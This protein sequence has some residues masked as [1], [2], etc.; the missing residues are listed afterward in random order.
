MR[1]FALSSIPNQ[2]L[3]TALASWAMTVGADPVRVSD[4]PIENVLV[5]SDAA[6]AGAVSAG[7]ATSQDLDLPAGA[8]ATQLDVSELKDVYVKAD[9]AGQQVN[10]TAAVRKDVL[11]RRTSIVFKPGRAEPVF[12]S[13][14]GTTIPLTRG[15]DM[16][17]TRGTSRT[18]VDENGVL[19]TLDAHAMALPGSGWI[20]E[21]QRTNLLTYS[22]D[23]SSWTNRGTCTVTSG[24]ADPDGGT[25]AALLEDNDAAYNEARH[26]TITLATSTWYAA[27]VYLKAGSASTTSLYM[28]SGTGPHDFLVNVAWSG[29]VPTCTTSGSMTGIAHS[30]ESVGG[31]WYR[32]AFVFQTGASSTSYDLYIYPAGSTT[33]P[34][35]TT[36]AYRAQ[37]EAG[38]FPTSAIQTAGS[39]ASRTAGYQSATSR[40]TSAP[41]LDLA[42]ATT[43]KCQYNVLHGGATTGW[44]VSGGGTTPATLTAVTDVAE[45]VAAGLHHLVHD[46]Y[47]LKLDNSA[48]DANAFAE[49][50]GVVGSLNQHTCSVYW[51]GTGTGGVRLESDPAR[52]EAAPSE[53]ERISY[54]STPPLTNRQLV[55]D[56]S[57]GSTVYFVL[58][59]L[60]ERSSTTPVVPNATG[61]SVSR[62]GDDL[63]IMYSGGFDAAAGITAQIEYDPV[64]ATQPV[65]AT[66]LSVGDF[67]GTPSLYHYASGGTTYQARFA[68]ENGTTTETIA[69]PAAGQANVVTMALDPTSDEMRSWVGTAEETAQ[70]VTLPAHAAAWNDGKVMVANT[71]ARL[72]GL[73]VAP[74]V[75]TPS[76]LQ[77]LLQ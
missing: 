62:S 27:S 10:V 20:Y 44:T 67:A 30:P 15:A 16:S 60:E 59:Q 4:G 14:V 38:A 50:A 68:D 49:N 6:N 33:A 26:I 72:Y 45:L 23:F 42:P 63:S 12:A 51:R 53:Y 64:S 25:S 65:S 52:T 41:Y 76:V 31:G 36:Y 17:L 40:V 3:R 32:I 18:Y 34:T 77:T 69:S 73:V 47:V 57:A 11:E 24:Q 46:G 35:G 39:T 56:A 21:P 58:A 48:G 29:G 75:Y 55:V 74:G 28:Y 1:S 54:T 2:K 13:G 5:Q 7:D 19:R 43:N 70:S 66:I 71:L 61:A 8:A 37:L 9:Q 22:D